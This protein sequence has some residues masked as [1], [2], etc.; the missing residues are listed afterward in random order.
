MINSMVALGRLDPR[1]VSSIILVESGRDESRAR[2]VRKPSGSLRAISREAAKAAEKNAILKAL[3][4]AHW[5]RL[6]AA[7]L[8]NI[9]YWSVLY[10]IKEEGLDR[11]RTS[12]DLP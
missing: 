12:R 7:K 10:K 5:N 1:R 8:L 4:Q 11:K 2:R 9:S 3:K 6:L